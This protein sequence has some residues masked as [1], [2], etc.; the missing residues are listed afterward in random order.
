MAPDS[1]PHQELVDEIEM[2]FDRHFDADLYVPDARAAL[3]SL[4]EQ[5]QTARAIIRRGWDDHL[6]S[7]EMMNEEDE[8]WMRQW[9]GIE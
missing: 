8:K 5:V 7:F 1:K 3:A 4:V 2:G 6:Y 9:A